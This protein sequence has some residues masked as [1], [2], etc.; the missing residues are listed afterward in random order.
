MKHFGRAV[1][2]CEDSH[3]YLF[4][5][6]EDDLLV[7]PGDRFQPDDKQASDVVIR[8]F[9]TDLDVAVRVEPMPMM[10]FHNVRAGD[11]NEEEKEDIFALLI[12]EIKGIA[13]SIKTGQVWLDLVEIEAKDCTAIT[14]T[15]IQAIMHVRFSKEETSG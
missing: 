6:D 14:W 5:K 11:I 8:H 10:T 9:A 13:S 3:V 4:Q 15:I 7:F 2:I 1:G 12:L